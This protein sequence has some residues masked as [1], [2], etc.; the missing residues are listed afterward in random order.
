MSLTAAHL[1]DGIVNI[2]GGERSG[3]PSLVQVPGSPTPNEKEKKAKTPLLST[4]SSFCRVG[5]EGLVSARCMLPGVC[6]SVGRKPLA[7]CEVE[8]SP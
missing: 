2:P 6:S 8:A 3:T 7:T 1:G 4:P 5:W